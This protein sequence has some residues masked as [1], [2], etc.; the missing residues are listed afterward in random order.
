MGPP[1]R[2]A[3]GRARGATTQQSAG[4]AAVLSVQSGAAVVYVREA[5]TTSFDPYSQASSNVSQYIRSEAR[6]LV[7][8]R[9]HQPGLRI[10][11]VMT[12]RVI[13]RSKTPTVIVD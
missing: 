9:R 8:S 6:A 5:S 3:R 12:A 2:K 10:A 4:K 13:K 7:T 1:S 11:N